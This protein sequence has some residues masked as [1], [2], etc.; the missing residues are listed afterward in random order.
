MASAVP[1]TEASTVRTHPCWPL[2][3]HW[4]RLSLRAFD[5]LFDS[6]Q[7]RRAAIS[8]I[9][10]EARLFDVQRTSRD[11]P[12]TGLIRAKDGTLYGTTFDRGVGS[13]GDEAWGNLF[14]MPGLAA[15]HSS[16]FQPAGQQ[17]LAA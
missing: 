6:A 14:K 17:A 7:A 10:Q 4:L 3:H 12:A 1:P 2:S 9:R 16:R 5:G 13:K 15:V 8:V 11:L